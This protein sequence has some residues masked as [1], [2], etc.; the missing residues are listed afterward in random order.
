M[1]DMA[2]RKKGGRTPSSAVNNGVH[3][4]VP[5][6]KKRRAKPVQVTPQKSEVTRV[7]PI[8]GEDAK[9]QAEEEDMF[10]FD[11]HMREFT[12]WWQLPKSVPKLLNNTESS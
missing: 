5:K 11:E 1:V 8:S 9:L 4:N 2:S 7:E 6:K 10:D 3:E 12:K